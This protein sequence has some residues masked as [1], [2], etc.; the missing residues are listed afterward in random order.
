MYAFVGKILKPRG[1]FLEDVALR[2]DS[3]RLLLYLPKN[4][5]TV[6]FVVFLIRLTV[7]VKVNI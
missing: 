2:V 3:G 6:R 7:T 4:L 1:R 5:P